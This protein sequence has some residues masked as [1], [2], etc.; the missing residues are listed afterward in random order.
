MVHLI[1]NEKTLSRFAL[2]LLFGVDLE[3]D[4]E[5]HPQ[6]CTVVMCKASMKRDETNPGQFLAKTGRNIADQKS[7]SSEIIKYIYGVSVKNFYKHGLVES[8]DPVK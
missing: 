1:K 4:I 5:D 8:M 6:C 3:S 2:A 7:A